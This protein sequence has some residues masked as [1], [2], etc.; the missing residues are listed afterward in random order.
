MNV[1][2]A[3]GGLAQFPGT[4]V[5]GDA[6]PAQEAYP[7]DD[8][9]PESLALL[10]PCLASTAAAQGARL[11][12]QEGEQLIG[13]RRDN[14]LAESG[15]VGIHSCQRDSSSIMPSEP[16]LLEPCLSITLCTPVQTR[17]SVTDSGCSR[18]P[19]HLLCKQDIQNFEEVTFHYGQCICSE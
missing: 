11:Y 7:S 3:L 13:H 4:L 17:G 5:L 10:E 6:R 16:T 2:S 12:R 9:S 15:H 8:V 1:W 19:L 14:A 18:G